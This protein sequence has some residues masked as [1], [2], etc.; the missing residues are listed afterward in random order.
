MDQE[1][2]TIRAALLSLKPPYSAAILN[3]TKT[4]E[5]RKRKLADDIQ[6]VYMYTTA[7]TQAVLGYFTVRTQIVNKP[8]KLW[9][10]FSHTAGIRHQ[11]FLD[12]YKHTEQAVGIVIKKACRYPQPFPLTALDPRGK[13]PQSIKYLTYIPAHVTNAAT[14]PVV[15]QHRVRAS[16]PKQRQVE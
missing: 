15:P 11:Q 12:Y 5:F 6:T 9:E 14:Q 7:P 13:P 3:G 16:D 4:V 8:D 1:P 10:L 2:T